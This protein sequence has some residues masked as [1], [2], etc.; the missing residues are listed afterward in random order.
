MNG[1]YDKLNFGR[2]LNESGP[3]GFITS[4]VCHNYGSVS[5]CDEGC[6]ALLDGDCKNPKEALEEC[7]L[8]EGEKDNILKLYSFKKD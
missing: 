1:N 2:T 6:P 7:D 5:G 3:N 8:N 4:S